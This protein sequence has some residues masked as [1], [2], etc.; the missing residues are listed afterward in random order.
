MKTIKT[1]DITGK[2]VL[3]RVDFNVPLDENQNITDDSRIRAVL[4]TLEFA[5]AHRS[6]LILASHLGRPAGK[7][8]PAMSLSPVAERLGGFLQKD[9]KMAADCVGPAV[10]ALVAGMKEGDVV[11]LEN[12]R[13]H[14]EE[15]K[16][17]ETFAKALAALCDV[18]VND[19]FAVSHRADAS[20]VAVTRHVPVCAAGFLLQKELDYFEKAMSD[21]RRPLVAVIGGSKVSSKLGALENMLQYVDKMVIGGA[22]ANTFLK[23]KGYAMGKSKIEEDLI[24]VAGAVMKKADENGIS[25]YLPVDVVVASRFEPKSEVKIVPIQEIPLDWMAL[26]IGPAT[27]MLYSEALNDAG[28][29]VWNGPMGVFEMDAFSRGTI[30]MANSMANSNALTIAGGGD[31]DAAIHKAGMIDKITYIST[32]GGAFLELLEGKVLPAVAALQAAGA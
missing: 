20:I 26:D 10:K 31:T 5:R 19:A 21:P 30:E 29:I 14:P 7:V 9:V 23:F 11:L 4:P 22:M 16:N 6:M 15:Q 27:S 25:F 13:F 24:T 12:L 3:F 18:Y 28:T 2:R 8:V 17:D 1:I 32:G